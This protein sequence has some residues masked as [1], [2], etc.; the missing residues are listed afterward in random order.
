MPTIPPLFYENY[1]LTDFN[2]K[3]ELFNIFFSKQ[4]FL[5]RDDYSL[6]DDANYIADKRLST[7]AFSA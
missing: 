2:V 6:L 7:V 1:F 3:S 5:V 4:N